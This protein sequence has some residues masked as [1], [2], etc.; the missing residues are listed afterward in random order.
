LRVNIYAP[1]RGR[2]HARVEVDEGFDG[3]SK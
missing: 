1:G 2:V 3:L